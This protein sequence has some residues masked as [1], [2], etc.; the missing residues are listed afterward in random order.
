MEGENQELVSKDQVL[1]SFD[2]KTSKLDLVLILTELYGVDDY[3]NEFASLNIDKE[4]VELIKKI[5]DKSPKLFENISNRL[6]E[7][8]S[9]N[10]LNTDDVPVLV[11]L[12]K[13]ILNLSIPD[14]SDIE[15][16]VEKL[17]NLVKKLLELLINKDYIKVE[18][19]EK[20]FTLISISFELLSS[21]VNIKQD[22]FKSLVKFFNKIFTC[23]K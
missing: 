17:I 8:L 12:I 6:D 22:I 23:C 20:V 5:L 7:I 19:K 18:N 16:T 3:V 11:K 4:T 1:V 9:D 21:S 14:L 15:L 10:V 13:D 2:D